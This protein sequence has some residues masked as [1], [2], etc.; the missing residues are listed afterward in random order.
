MKKTVRI[1]LLTLG[2]AMF[3]WFI[4]RTGWD[5]I[6]GTFRELEI[7]GWFGLVVLIPYTIVF[8]I[9]TMGWRFTFGSTALKG[10][11]FYVTWVIRLVGESINNV[12]PTM[13]VGGEVAKIYLLKCRNVTV[14]T[15]ASAAVRSKTAQSVAQS[16]FIAMGAA[17]AAFTLPAE[18]VGVKWAFAG[19][20][21]IGFTMMIL[22]FKIQKHG[23]FTTL[24]SWVRKLGF[25]F[26]S[27]A[28][29]EGKI[30]ELDDQIYDFY[31]QDKRHFYWCTC[32]YLIGWM[33]DTLEIMIVAYL[34]GAEVAWHHAFAMEAFISIARGFNIVVPGALGVQ[35]FGVVGLFALF[36]YGPEL[37]TK[38]AI[39]RRGRDVIF[40]SFGWFAL[41]LGEVTWKDIRRD[42]QEVES[43]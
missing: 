42:I 19:M 34:L 32:T 40:A 30:R 35:E 11:P 23:M 38:Y 1:I 14:I 26:Q 8:T 33:F 24:L 22:L 31:N 7:H 25:R 15:A 39:I 6:R 2:L 9:D 18:H 41:Y 4:Q 20:A 10:I 29:K 36:S 17:V 5:D 3:A 12:I 37:G 43:E 28:S 13:Y 27:L 21:V 16:T